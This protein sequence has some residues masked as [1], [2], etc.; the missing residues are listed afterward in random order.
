MRCRV[1]LATLVFGASLA[2]TSSVVLAQAPSWT[3]L[4][5]A[6]I[7]GK[8]PIVKV[9]LPEGTQRVQALA[10]VAQRGTIALARV[11]VSYNTGQ[12]HFEE[13]PISLRKGERSRAIDERK[14]ARI[15]ESVSLILQKGGSAQQ[16]AEIEIWGLAPAVQAKTRGR[17]PKRYI[18]MPVFYGT[19]R[20]RE[21][22][23]TKNNQTLATFS[24]ELGQDLI[25][26]RAIVTVPTEREPGTIPRPETNLLIM[27][28]A[29][30]NEE[31]NRD[32][33]IASVE[34]MAKDEF[35]AE[36]RKQ[37]AVSKRYKDQAF[38]FVHGYNVSFDDALFRTAQIAHD[39]GFDGPAVTFSWP[40]RGGA[41]D[42]VHDINTAKGSR[43]GLRTLLETIA[44]DTNVTSVNLVAHSMGN[45]PT[46]EV[47][48]EQAEIIARKGQ[49][50][51]FKLNEVVLAAPDVSRSV[52]ERF[53]ARVASVV[54]GGITLLAS[55]ND[56]AMSASKRVA[57][58]L[59]RAG[60]I[61]KEGIVIVPGIESI[62]VSEASTAFLSTNH[63]AFA[64]REHLVTDLRYL[65]E[66][67]DRKHPPDVRYKIYRPA[68]SQ[69]K[70]WWQ[71]KK[72]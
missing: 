5:S 67:A 28:I 19:T 1:L 45:D 55:K 47:L 63:S 44:Q 23:R 38:V 16:A 29:F 27:R 21:D 53:A 64:D 36:M 46:I 50:I 18:E 26:G 59:V 33:T 22:D 34:V 17:E 37:V 31:P 14:E 56:L 70:Q 52:F 11:V 12:M 61:P 35:A 8:S 32:F 69:P 72:D 60:D 13:R 68:G 39:I 62:D 41:W 3:R 49:T 66:R 58:G 54:K 25:L 2:S 48:R 40:S 30:R 6:P 57:S 42:Y 51:D 65:F 9:A 7:D 43:D 10:L 71:Y 24:G 15:V 4:H 20:Q